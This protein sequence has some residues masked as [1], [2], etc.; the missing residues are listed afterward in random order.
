M[1]VSLADSLLITSEDDQLMIGAEGHT[2]ISAKFDFSVDP[3]LTLNHL[4]RKSYQP[5][6]IYAI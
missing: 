5:P 4:L 6:F 1:C 3:Q 2:D